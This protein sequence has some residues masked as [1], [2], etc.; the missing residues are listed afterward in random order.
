MDTNYVFSEVR[1]E[2]LHNLIR[3]SPITLPFDV[4]QGKVLAVT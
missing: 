3:H 2:P 4:T 1:T